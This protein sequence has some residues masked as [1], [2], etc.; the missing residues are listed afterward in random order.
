LRTDQLPRERKARLGRRRYAH[1]PLAEWQVS[2]PA[3]RDRRKWTAKHEA[4]LSELARA[5]TCL[6]RNRD[7]RRSDA[8]RGLR[9]CL[10]SSL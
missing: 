5:S 6:I 8:F 2:A 7:Q 4:V 10:A 1:Q 3:C 9:A